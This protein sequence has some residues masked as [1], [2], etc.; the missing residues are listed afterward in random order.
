M[1]SLAG[2]YWLDCPPLFVLLPNESVWSHCIRSLSCAGLHCM[3]RSRYFIFEWFMQV[4]R[5]WAASWKSFRSIVGWFCQSWWIDY[6]IGCLVQSNGFDLYSS[7]NYEDLCNLLGGFSLAATFF[8]LGGA[9]MVF[10]FVCSGRLVYQFKGAGPTPPPPPPFTSTPEPLPPP[11][12]ALLASQE[13]NDNSPVTAVA[14]IA[15]MKPSS[16]VVV[17]PKDV[18]GG[19]DEE[20]EIDMI[21]I[22][23]MH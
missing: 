17:N 10:V 1:R 4:R 11:L 3:F 18:G 8:L 19:E 13:A 14:T 23:L 9:E 5:L 22:H 20:E 2:N 21:S 12:H 15:D 7:S 16:H 6:P